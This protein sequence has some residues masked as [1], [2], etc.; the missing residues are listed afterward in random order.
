MIFVCL[1]C[2]LRLD[3][4]IK[5]YALEPKFFVRLVAGL[6]GNLHTQFLRCS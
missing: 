2:N 1:V 4:R 5:L 3:V 6:S